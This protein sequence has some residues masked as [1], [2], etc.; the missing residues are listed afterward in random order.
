[1]VDLKIQYSCI[2]QEVDEVVLEVIC[3][4]VFINGL[5][6]QFFKVVFSVYF[7]VKYVIFCVNGIDVL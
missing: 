3:F 2:Q 6:V 4:I 1:M 7:D 5:K